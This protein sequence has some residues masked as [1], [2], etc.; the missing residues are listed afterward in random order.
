MI[1][2]ARANILGENIS[3]VSKGAPFSF[4]KKIK[5]EDWDIPGGPVLRLCTPSARS[6]GSTPTWGTKIP[7]AAL[8]I[9]PKKKV[10]IIVIISKKQNELDPLLR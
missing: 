3:K 6:T 1:I 4:A 2:S 5:K 10:D 9:Q 7:R 8:C